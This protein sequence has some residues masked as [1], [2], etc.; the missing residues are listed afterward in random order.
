MLYLSIPMKERKKE[1]CA[2]QNKDIIKNGDGRKV[3]QE[4]FKWNIHNFCDLPNFSF[5]AKLVEAFG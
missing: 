3:G 1:G 2:D 5:M 4:I